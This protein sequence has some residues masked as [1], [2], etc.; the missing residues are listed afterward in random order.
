MLVPIPF[1]LV[2]PLMIGVYFASPWCINKI[3]YALWK[4]GWK[5]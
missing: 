4:M 5:R 1:W 3:E 2:L